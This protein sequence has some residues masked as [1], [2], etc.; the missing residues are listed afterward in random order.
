MHN[1]E[2]CDYV[3]VVQRKKKKQKEKEFH[4]LFE[5]SIINKKFRVKF[6]RAWYFKTPKNSAVGNWSSEWR[7][8]EA[9]SFKCGSYQNLTYGVKKKSMSLGTVQR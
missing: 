6:H 5:Y 2:A 7:L 4:V 9:V 1:S 3:T 8:I